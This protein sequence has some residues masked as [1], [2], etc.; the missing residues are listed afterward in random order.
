MAF[1]TEQSYITLLDLEGT[2]IKSWEDPTWISVGEN[3]RKYVTGEWLGPPGEG[4]ARL[5]LMSW[6]VYNDRDKA[7]F[8]KSIRPWLEERINKKFDD[9][10]ILSMDDWADRVFEATNCKVSRED[11]FD[12]CK[13][14]DVLFK[15]RKH[16]MFHHTCTFLLDDA[17]DKHLYIECLDNKS[18]FLIRNVVSLFD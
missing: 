1:D 8:N 18:K 12:V 4:L 13:K 10:L 17:V 3:V 16:P 15:L 5:G 6:A 2:V 14:E 9:D 7:I 11:M